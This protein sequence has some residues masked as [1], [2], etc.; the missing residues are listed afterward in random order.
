MRVVG[1]AGHVD[2]GKST[3]V[4]ALTGI[5]P[6]RLKEEQTR[7]M[8][9]ELGFAWL[10]LPG[11]E[12]VGI[13][14]VPGHRDFIENMLAG[15]G[16][17]D[18]ALFVIAVDEGVMPQTRE[19][20]AILDLLQIHGGVIALTKMDMAESSEWTEL[21]EE[22]VRRVMQG[23]ILENAPIVRV[24]ARNGSGLDELKHVLADI[25]K[26]SPPRL[27]LGRPRLPID[28]VFSIAGF[29]TVVT[30]TL[31]DG[32]LHIG[33]EV[34]ILPSGLSGRIRGL[35]NHRRKEEI[36]LPGGRT[37][38]NINGI[39]VNQIQRG[40][41][42]S[43]PGTYH[44]TRRVDVNFRLLKDAS[45]PLKHYAEVKLFIGA[46][47]VQ[48]RVRL[49]G[50]EQINPGNEGW[51]QI[52]LAQPVVAVRGDRYILRRPSPGE[53]MGGGMVIDPQPKGRHK[54]FAKDI[55]LRLRELGEGSALDILLQ[56]CQAHG[57]APISKI[58]SQ[59][60]LS[61]DQFIQTIQEAVTSGR[62]VDLEHTQ[63]FTPKSESLI[64]T[65]IQWEKETQKILVEIEQYH[66]H[67]PFRKGIPREELKSR[68]KYPARLFSSLL[69]N[70]TQVSRIT[71]SGNFVASVAHRIEYNEKQKEKVDL[72]FKHFDE[73][74]YSPPTVEECQNEIGEEIT[75]ALVDLGEL[76]MVSADIVFRKRDY[77]YLV[78]EVKSIIS[79]QGEITVANF[80]DRFKT[81]RRYA[82]AFLEYLDAVGV[83]I[84][85][86]DK[87]IIKQH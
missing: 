26:E 85:D 15:V 21:V 2:H 18:A 5:N 58:F 66:N 41:I 51:L 54:R 67:F 9:I 81:S 31:S 38:V 87:R 71:E 45:Q 77:E 25:L 55:I 12:E 42:L 61:D 7:E 82:L 32:K 49:L 10:T 6:D 20:L 3:L 48:G 33:E 84:R 62:I 68:L 63:D 36:A 64:M 76:V 78:S 22:D 40:E 35:Q 29:G 86:G 65:Q 70:L 34:E 23:T 83:T 57:A 50:V 16:G 80:R 74:P 47:E 13:V 28:R 69:Q 14:D 8:T 46:A 56:V 52:E 59:T 30:G 43:H 27:D 37:A 24:S 53:T 44:T 4:K 79:N 60:Q 75:S 39:D 19:H 11:A 73:R 1:T 17:I 72:L